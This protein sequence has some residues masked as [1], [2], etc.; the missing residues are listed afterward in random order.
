MIKCFAKRITFWILTLQMRGGKQNL[1]RQMFSCCQVFVPLKRV[2]FL[3]ACDHSYRSVW[4]LPLGPTVS[5]KAILRIRTCLQCS[6]Q[7]LQSAISTVLKCEGD[8]MSI[9]LTGV[10]AAGRNWKGV[11]RIDH[12]QNEWPL[13]APLRFTECL[14]IGPKCS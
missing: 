3:L 10:W 4:R 2:M 8:V 6:L 12:R 7:E 1:I 5:P 14:W 9:I 13:R 11:S